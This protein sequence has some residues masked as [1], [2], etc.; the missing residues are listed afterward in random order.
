M[1]DSV[2]FYRSFYEAVRELPP[3]DFKKSVCAIMNYGLDDKEPETSGIE[4]TIHLLTKPQIDANNRRY[5]NGTKGGRKKT[6]QEPN[7]NQTLT[8][9]YPKENVKEKDNVN[10][11]DKKESIEKKRFAPPTRQDVADYV[12]EKGY[13][14]VDIDRFI[15]YYSSN[16]WMVGK[17]K[18]KDWRA[19]VRNWNRSQRQE[20]TTKGSSNK[21]LNFDQ[22]EYDYDALEKQLLERSR[23]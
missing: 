9:T 2:V 14:N 1:R 4:K 12:R 21:F 8:K 13:A 5:Q 23:S 20:S 16:G 11:N 19:A 3:E 17:N 6:E 22:R 7:A 10:V 18:M 15:D